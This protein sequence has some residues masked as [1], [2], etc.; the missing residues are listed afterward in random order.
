MT[1]DLFKELEEK[2]EQC[3]DILRQLEAQARDGTNQIKQMETAL[4]MCKEEINTYIGALEETK[5]VYD[6][7]IEQR[8]EKVTYK[9]TNSMGANLKGYK[10]HG[11]KLEA[12]KL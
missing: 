9:Q 1:F 6:R 10:L 12:Y 2:K 8:D 5:E 3:R 4:T 11:C 7:E